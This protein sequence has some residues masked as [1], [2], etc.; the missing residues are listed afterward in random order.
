VKI[1]IGAY[2]GKGKGT[3]LG[4]VGVY[5][6]KM[7]KPVRVLWLPQHGNGKGRDGPP[8]LSGT[9]RPEARGKRRKQNT[10]KRKR[11]A[12]VHVPLLV[13]MRLYPQPTD[14]IKKPSS[15][16]KVTH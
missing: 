10:K 8:P 14:R 1:V 3:A 13:L 16:V 15:R 7:G 6:V 11:P 2:G 9:L 12:Y 4:C 5:I